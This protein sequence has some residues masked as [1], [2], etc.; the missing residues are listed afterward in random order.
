MLIMQK[1]S[2]LKR[3]P[4]GGIRAKGFLK[5]QLIR[6]KHGMAGHLY[7]LEPGIIADP[8]VRK[9]KVSAWTDVN[10]SGWAGEISANYWNG[11]IQHA[12]I[13]N[14]VEMMER[15]TKW[16]DD[17]MKNQKKDGYLGTYYE[18]DADIYDDFNGWATASAMRAL[19][20]FHEVTGRED[21]LEAVHRCLLWFCDTWA[22]DKKKTYAGE[23]LIEPMVF[24]YCRT[25]DERLLEFAEDYAE[26]L[27]TKDIYPNS[28]RSFLEDEYQYTT[29]HTVAAGMTA[30][31]PVLLYAV[32]GKEKYIEASEK[33]IGMLR[34]KSVHLSGGPVS[35]AEFLGPVSMTAESEYCNFTHFNTTYAYLSYITGN[36]KYGDYVE[37]MFYNAA[38]GARKKDEKAIAYLTA[39]NQAYATET[40]SSTGANAHDQVYAPCTPVACCPANAVALVPEFIRD[41]MF[42]D[43]DKNVYIA[44]YGPCHLQCEERDIEVKTLYPFR[45]KVEVHVN[46]EGN[47]GV[48]LR[49]PQWA[50]GYQLTVNGKD[51]EAVANERGYVEVHQLWKKG[52]IVEIVFKT[53]PKV[54]RV[55]D[56]DASKKYPIAIKYGTLL[57]SYH[58]PERWEE[59]PGEPVTPLPE[60]WSW[61]NVKPVYPSQVGG[62]EHDCFGT[63]RR[64]ISWN[65]ALDEELK[66]EDITVE[67][68]EE[69]GYAWEN[70]MIKLHT[71][72][73][74]APY[75]YPPYPI[76]TLEPAKDKHTVTEKLPLVLE[77]YGCTNLR[78]SYFP[79]ADVKKG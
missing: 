22:G 10:Q 69:K 59:T 51:F 23:Y 29:L 70:P 58:I 12:F 4:L 54:I 47:Y 32:T 26:F 41:M 30:R 68:V 75:L 57:F 49:I 37:E 79:R 27:C 39:P 45:N 42:F 74:K 34:E 67:E 19:L 3:V 38:Q 17:M 72:C 78:I 65:I 46:S 21:V 5:E 77:P 14:D 55:D 40:S 8:Y 20:N 71:E 28:Y 35:I 61:F 48:F 63:N 16:V 50:E 60:G 31:L 66:P 64:R 52:N 18:E 24:C 2:R 43:E 53:S 7:E 56:S 9:S 15:A 76:R 73:Y 11:Y 1:Y 13:L 62:D 25:K 36:G 6:G 33:F 44:L